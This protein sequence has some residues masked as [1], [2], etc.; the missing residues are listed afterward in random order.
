MAR[1]NGQNAV[2]VIARV[3]DNGFARL[4]VAENRVVS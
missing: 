4:L 2:D 3:D 1:E